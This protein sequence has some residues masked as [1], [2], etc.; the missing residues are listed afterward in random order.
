LLD[1]V[2][3]IIKYLDE[4]VLDLETD[5]FSFLGFFGFIQ[6]FVEVS[7][8]MV[9]FSFAHNKFNGNGHWNTNLVNCL[10]KSTLLSQKSQV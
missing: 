5:V 9:S 3:V 4:P 1:A 10:K 7:D 6:L 8:Q 2:K